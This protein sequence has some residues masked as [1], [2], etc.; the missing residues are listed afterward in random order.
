MKKRK[1]G[2]TVS[3]FLCWFSSFCF[4]FC[5]IPNSL[6]GIKHISN[7]LRREDEQIFLAPKSNIFVLNFHICLYQVMTFLQPNQIGRNNNTQ[8]TVTFSERHFPKKMWFLAFFQIFRENIQIFLKQLKFYIS[9]NFE[10]KPKY[11]VKF[12]LL[13]F[14]TC[15]KS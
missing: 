1:K 14:L 15:Q 10:T 13:K 3:F 5:S 7:G 12:K 9:F 4:Y 6:G 11:W 8:R 2:E